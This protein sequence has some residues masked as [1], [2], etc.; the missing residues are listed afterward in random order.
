MNLSQPLSLEEQ[1]HPLSD[2]DFL[3]DEGL[4][5]NESPVKNDEVLQDRERAN[6]NRG[7]KLRVN[8]PQARFPDF[9]PEFEH[10]PV[11]SF[12]EV[13]AVLDEKSQSK[14]EKGHVFEQLV[15][16]F[17]EGGQGPI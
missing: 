9:F 3:P 1:H 12:Q 8:D 14:R 2:T 5:L 6:G 11:S 15:K 4:F 7:A 13:L 16:A 17:I 10:G